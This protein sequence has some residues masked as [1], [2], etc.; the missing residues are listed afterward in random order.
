MNPTSSQ[1]VNHLPWE[2]SS[3]TTSHLGIAHNST[4]PPKPSACVV[5]TEPW[6]CL[7]SRLLAHRSGLRTNITRSE[8]AK[9]CLGEEITNTP[10][11]IDIGTWKK[12]AGG[13]RDSVRKP[14]LLRLYGH[15]QGCRWG[16]GWWFPLG[17]FVLGACKENMEGGGKMRKDA[18]LSSTVPSITLKTSKNQFAIFISL[19]LRHETRNKTHHKSEKKEQLLVAQQIEVLKPGKKRKN[20]NHKKKHHLRTMYSSVNFDP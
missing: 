4:G 19:A 10:R 16:D 15:F 9:A 5:G 11:Q 18:K 3:P 8:A 6:R 14:S 13:R 12:D 20:K 17:F 1:L 2:T 7:S